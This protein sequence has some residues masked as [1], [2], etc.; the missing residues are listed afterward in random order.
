MVG[1][2]GNQADHASTFVYH[3]SFH[4]RTLVSCSGSFFKQERDELKIVL[5]SF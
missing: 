2:V 4:L 5:T 1:E 3:F